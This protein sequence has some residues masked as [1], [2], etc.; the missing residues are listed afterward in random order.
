M[1]HALIGSLHEKT[2]RKWQEQIRHLRK[3]SSVLLK[4]A[5]AACECAHIFE[6]TSALN[7]LSRKSNVMFKYI[8]HVLVSLH[9]C[10][11]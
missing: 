5:R 11:Y 3:I 6:S 4:A 2:Y 10:R 1:D 7:N 9:L 8:P